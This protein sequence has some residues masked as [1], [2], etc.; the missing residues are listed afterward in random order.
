MKNYTM[1][2]EGH[3]KKSS[4]EEMA[5]DALFPYQDI[6]G[7]QG[8]IF[9]CLQLAEPHVYPPLV[10][11]IGPTGILNHIREAAVNLQV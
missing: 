11:L 10:A 7:S 2:C 5:T 9:I 4:N 8:G 6:T 3:M 1:H